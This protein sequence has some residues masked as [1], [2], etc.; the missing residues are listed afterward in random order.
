MATEALQQLNSVDVAALHK[1]LLHY[2][3]TTDFRPQQL[4]AVQATLKVLW[5]QLVLPLCNNCLASAT[6]QVM[7]T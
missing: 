4:E 2:W 5:D 6:S 3:N 1:V 7:L